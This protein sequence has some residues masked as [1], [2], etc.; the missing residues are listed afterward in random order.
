MTEFEEEK[1][2]RKEMIFLLIAMVVFFGIG[3]QLVAFFLIACFWDYNPLLAIGGVTTL[4]ILIGLW[5][6]FALKTKIRNHPRPF[7]A[8]LEEFENDIEGLHAFMD[9]TA[10][11]RRKSTDTDGEV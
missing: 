9:S 3:L 10:R 8:T 4:Y 11:K 6:L 7:S 5:A 1:E 2:R